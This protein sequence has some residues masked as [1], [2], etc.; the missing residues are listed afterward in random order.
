MEYLTLLATA[1]WGLNCCVGGGGGGGS[2][3]RT[4]K[5]YIRIYQS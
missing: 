4:P 3:A 2:E 5:T 1:F